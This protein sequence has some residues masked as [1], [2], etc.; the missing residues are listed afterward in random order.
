MKNNQPITNNEVTFA[1][2]EEII[3]TTDLKGA[4]TSYNQAFLAIS[5]FSPEELAGINHNIVRHPDMPPAAYADLWQNLK[6]EKHWMGIVKNRCA[7]GDYYWVDAY[8]TPM[9]ENGQVVGY[10]SV[11]SKPSPER[12][13]RAQKIY[14]A[15]NAGL[16]PVLG[17]FWQRLSLSN[18]TIIANTASLLVAG[19]TVFATQSTLGSTSFLAGAIIGIGFSYLS[20]QWALAP[21]TQAAKVAQKEVNNPL[22]AL[23]YTGRSDEIGQIQLPRMMLQAK[24]RTILGRISDA[25][26]HITQSAHHSS[27]ATQ[28]INQSLHSQAGETDLVA[29]AITEMT[30]SVSEVARTAAHAASVAADADSHSQDGVRNAS[31]AADGLHTMT[32]AIDNIAD[33]IAQLAKDTKN[34]DAILNVIQSVAEQTN[35]LALNAA[36]EAARA[37][38]HGRGF[39]VVADEVRTLASRTQ[40]STEEIQSL[41][42]KL[43]RA[44][45]TAVSVLGNSQKSA[46][47]SENQIT[48]AIDSLKGIATQIHS[49]ND[50]NAQIATAVK[51]QTSVSEEVSGNVNRISHASAQA[52]NGANEAKNSAEELANQASDLQNMLV[53]FSKG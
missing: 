13:E 49:I 35:L 24:I 37:G 29:T 43:N 34:I 1:D 12:V 18:R 23:I 16:K 27:T 52:L 7:N 14:R 8:I 6:A 53:R 32:T 46:S 30:A 10:E 5:G 25:A 20:N 36:I 15:I 31:G 50:L 41:I 33:V 17:G 21:L 44:V 19:A 3:S 11:R 48:N 51:E 39:A 40:K 47:Q 28:E 22:M 2:G 4:I 9:I 42:G 38:E 45:E 26:F